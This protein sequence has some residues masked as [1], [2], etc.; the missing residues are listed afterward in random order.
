MKLLTLALLFVCALFSSG[1][2]VHSSKDPAVGDA[3]VLAARLVGG[4]AVPPPGGCLAGDDC[5]VGELLHRQVQEPG[6]L[7]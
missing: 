6:Y 1:A 3:K 4:A 2:P 5:E 7:T